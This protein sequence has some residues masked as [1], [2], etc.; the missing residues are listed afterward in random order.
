MSTL[1]STAPGGATAQARYRPM[2]LSTAAASRG[3]PATSTGNSASL[4]TTQACAL[5]GRILQDY[6]SWIPSRRRRDS[7]CTAALL[8]APQDLA[9]APAKAAAPPAPDVEEFSS[10]NNGPIAREARVAAFQPRNALF[11]IT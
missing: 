10:F 6:G 3:G 8:S 4:A 11:R 7:D 5:T 9:P 1:R 2:T